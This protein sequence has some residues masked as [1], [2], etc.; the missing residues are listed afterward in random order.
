M[1][2]E[3]NSHVD[4]QRIAD[5]ALGN[6]G[7]S[8]ISLKMH[9][10]TGKYAN[11]GINRK[12]HQATGKYANSG[13]NRKTHQDSGS[14]YK[15][16]IR[17]NGHLDSGSLAKSGSDQILEI[18]RKMTHSVGPNIQGSGRRGSISTERYLVASAT[19]FLVTVSVL[20]LS[21]SF[22][23]AFP[24][25]CLSW[26]VSW[27][28]LGNRATREGKAM[29]QVWPEVVD[30]LI[31][32][33]QAGLS[34]SEAIAALSTRGPEI[35]R[36]DFLDFKISLLETGDFRQGIEK[37]KNRFHSQTSDQIL[38]AILMAKIMGGSE[39]LE[40]FRTLGDFTRQDLALRK[41]IE[42]KHGW[43]KNSAHLAS[44]APWLLLLLLSSQPGTVDSYSRPGGVL[45]LS[46]GLLMTL[47]AYLWMGRL[48]RLPE[49]PRI[50][51]GSTSQYFNR[52]TFI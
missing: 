26:A 9:S 17:G 6:L 31:S 33:T 41:E 10:A 43:I 19:S 4:H 29:L 23:I 46:L 11:S 30:H 15:P 49:A 52:Q 18:D 37:L 8:G 2:S 34:L 27:A 35:I 48:G 44:V 21:R 25:T 5:V 47:V 12:T 39:L 20:L 16:G 42:I 36:A 1:D 3:G 13:I 7:S 38:E 45:I 50:F 32:G 14:F 22:I 40:I 28:Y 24:F 51:S